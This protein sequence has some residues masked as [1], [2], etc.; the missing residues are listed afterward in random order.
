[1]LIDEPV[2]GAHHRPC[3][4]QPTRPPPDPDFSRP[5]PCLRPGRSCRMRVYSEQVRHA[6]RGEALGVVEGLVG[7]DVAEHLAA[8]LVIVVHQGD[9]TTR[10]NH[11]RRAVGHMHPQHV[12]RVGESGTIGAVLRHA[13]KQ[14]VQIC[15]M[16]HRMEL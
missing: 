5:L 8:L 15:M 7:R 4:K 2:V 10:P 13:F 14:S 6:R 12:A 9:L 16:R 11:P 3:P 1:M